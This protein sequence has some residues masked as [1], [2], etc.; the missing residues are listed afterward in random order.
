MILCDLCGEAKECLQ[1]VID[2]KEFDIC[3]DCWR[4]LEEKRKGKG[5]AKKTREIVS[6]LRR[7]YRSENRKSQ[8]PCQDSRRRFLVGRRGRIR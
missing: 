3:A 4:P 7:L 8:S 2:G 1:R 5:P 6:C